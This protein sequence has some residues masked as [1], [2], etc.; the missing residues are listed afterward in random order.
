MERTE[1]YTVEDCMPTDGQVLQDKVLVLNPDALKPEHRRPEHQLWE[2]KDGFGCFPICSG[3]AVFAK[4]LATG[5]ECRWER[6]DFIGILK[7]EFIPRGG[8]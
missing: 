6:E 2:A 5:Y 1:L 4:E 7:D 3:T 8:G